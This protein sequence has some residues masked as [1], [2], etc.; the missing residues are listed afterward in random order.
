MPPCT[1]RSATRRPRR[2]AP[3][4][5]R[6]CPGTAGPAG[7]SQAGQKTDKTPTRKEHWAGVP[8]T[9]GLK[10]PA[11]A[12]ARYAADGDDRPSR[13]GSQAAAAANVTRRSSRTEPERRSAPASAAQQTP[14]ASGQGPRRPAR[15]SGRTMSE[16]ASRHSPPNSRICSAVSLSDVRP[17]YCCGRQSP[18]TS[19]P[20][21]AHCG[22]TSRPTRPANDSVASPPSTAVMAAAPVTPCTQKPAASSIG[23]PGRTVGYSDVPRARNPVL[24]KLS[25]GCAP[26]NAASACGTAASHAAQSSSQSAGKCQDH[27]GRSAPTNSRSAAIR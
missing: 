26:P 2:P 7:S 22:P 3:P 11:A 8:G 16:S 13:L 18:R 4:C 21:G 19:A 6:P 1:S 5:A 17:T 15:S 24:A 10:G 12:D 23:S 25:P 20:A 27:G 9:R 14:A